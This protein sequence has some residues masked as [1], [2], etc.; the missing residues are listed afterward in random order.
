[1]CTRHLFANRRETSC[2]F[3]LILG[4]ALIS[5][6]SAASTPYGSSEILP[7]KLVCGPFPSWL[8]QLLLPHSLKILKPIHDPQ[9]ST[10][11]TINKT[12]NCQHCGLSLPKENKVLKFSLLK[13]QPVGERK[14]TLNY[15][16]L[17]HFKK[18]HKGP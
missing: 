15:L 17:T 10:L 13:V 3:S 4:A 16:K 2:L 12:A 1:M 14:K 11:T 6:D 9:N 8:Q 5:G 18:R 7:I